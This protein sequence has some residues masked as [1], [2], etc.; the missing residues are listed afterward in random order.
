MTS[1]K[2]DNEEEQKILENEDLENLLDD[3]SENRNGDTYKVLGD[4]MARLALNVNNKEKEDD[5][6]IQITYQD[7]AN[8][9]PNLN[10]M[11]NLKTG[12]GETKN[13]GKVKFGAVVK[14]NTQS[15]K[16]DS[17]K[18][19]NT[20]NKNKNLLKSKTENIQNDNNKVSLNNSY[21]NSNGN[22]LTTNSAT[23][24]TNINSSRDR[25]FLY[26]N[27]NNQNNNMSNISGSN[28]NKNNNV[29]VKNSNQVNLTSKSL[30]P[31]PQNK[32]N[33]N[34]SI[35]KLA[36]QNKTPNTFNRNYNDNN[37]FSKPNYSNNNTNTISNS[38]S[39]NSG[40][41]NLDL[42]FNESINSDELEH[43]EIEIINPEELED[44]ESDLSGLNPLIPEKKVVVKSGKLSLYEREMKNLKKKENRLDKERKLIIQKKLNNLQEGPAINEKSH[45]IIANS[46]DYVP[47]YQRAAQIHN[48]HLTQIV[49]NEE[50]KRME[51]KKEEDNEY[52]EIQKKKKVRKYEKEKWDNFVESCYKWDEEV[53]YKRKA[54]EIFKN[55]ME[56]HRPQINS[57]SKRIVKKLQKGNN[58]VD[59][60]YTRLYN[61]YEE[62]KERQKILENENMP[63]FAPKINQ[64]KYF[65]KFV[66]KRKYN[67]TNNSLD[68]FV[69][70][71]KK[72]K[73]FLE[74]QFKIIGDT[75]NTKRTKKQKKNKVKNTN[76]YLN[77]SNEKAKMKSKKY[78]KN[79]RPTQ[80]TNNSTIGLLNTEGN[81]LGFTNRYITT[82][83]PI[84]TESNQFYLPTSYNNYNNA[85]DDKINEISEN[86]L[87]PN[88]A[89]NSFKNNNYFAAVADEEVIDFNN[90]DGNYS[91]YNQSYDNNNDYNNYQNLNKNN[92]NNE[93]I[94]S[95]TI[96]KNKNINNNDMIYNNMKNNYNE[97]ENNFKNKNSN[98]F[99]N[100]EQ[101]IINKNIK[102][103]QNNL[104]EERN[105]INDTNNNTTFENVNASN[106]NCCIGSEQMF[107]DEEILQEL[108]EVK[109]KTKERQEKN[110]ENISERSEDDPLYRLNVRDSTPDNI[111]E[112]VVI[113]SNKY[114]NFFDVEE[115]QEL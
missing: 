94:N 62:H 113:P 81:T 110:G 102:N 10:H 3:D 34:N 60:V 49:L 115:I 6:D 112:N 72:N 19:N 21:K 33:N 61:D 82:E 55:R 67:N 14:A 96:N 104:E 54:A 45:I 52:E 66:N 43:Y 103:N 69:S 76:N 16:Q 88:Y 101:E 59:D 39:N 74:S 68:R 75:I 73:F 1:E 93:C 36:K 38:R 56:G 13:K 50:L 108:N 80:E 28:I 111:K 46:G 85:S 79:Y 4:E 47:L 2:E 20:D 91:H 107:K 98:D 105:N 109:L 15:I 97:Y 48:K 27:S 87:M 95:P 78:D 99:Q 100:N 114:Q 8:K 106:M 92:I 11:P 71:D 25:N 17:K 18:K 57:K 70:D 53:K 65:N 9:A 30:I 32:N 40:Q 58:S 5:N 90:T 23:A 42:K 26:N 22:V 29:I 7:L 35:S 24:N 63:P 37:Y 12:G 64:V 89:E 84:I 41:N 44:D 77:I 31:K 83:N 51:K 86:N